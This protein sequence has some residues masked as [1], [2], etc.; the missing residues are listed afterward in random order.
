M[1]APQNRIAPTTSRWAQLDL[2][3]TALPYSLVFL[4]SA[5]PDTAHGLSDSV[6]DTFSCKLC[7]EEFL[8]KLRR[9]RGNS[10]RICSGV[11]AASER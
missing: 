6:Y 11:L 5:T 2:C 4:C 1:V 10:E 9:G 8:T 7:F 3:Q